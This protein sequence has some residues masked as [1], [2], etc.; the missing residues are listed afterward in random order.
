MFSVI[1]VTSFFIVLQ[2]NHFFNLSTATRSPQ[3]RQKRPQ[4]QQLHS[5][6]LTKRCCLT[7]IQY[8][9]EWKVADWK[10]L[11]Y[12]SDPR[13]LLININFSFKKACCS[14]LLL[15]H[16]TQECFMN[17]GPGV[18]FC[19]IFYSGVSYLSSGKNNRIFDYCWSVT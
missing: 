11:E 18:F 10:T 6:Q 7:R 5:A 12:S 13:S 14:R 16:L 1:D 15:F 17:L 19:L 3:C 4:R 8:R 9:G 2:F